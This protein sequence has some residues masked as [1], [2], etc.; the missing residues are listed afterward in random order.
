MLEKENLE[1]IDVL[2][3]NAHTGW[4]INRRVTAGE[5]IGMEDRKGRRA[6]WG[7]YGK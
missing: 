2:D 3:C 1:Q 6:R 7:T 4:K 5:E